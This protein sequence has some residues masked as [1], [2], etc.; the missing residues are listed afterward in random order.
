[1]AEQETPLSGGNVTPVVR[2]G[3]TVRRAAG[4]W[5]P[6]VHSLLHYLEARGFD[7]APRALGFDDQGREV[8]T[9]IEGEIGQYPVPQPLWSETVL[10]E[11]ARFIRRYHDATVGFVP[12]EGAC[13]QFVYP[14]PRR[15]EVL[16][17]NDLGP[18]NLIYVG[19][20]PRA[21][22]DFD[23]AG[24]GPR[25]WDLAYAAYCFVPL[26]HAEDAGLQRLGLTAPTIQGQRLGRFCAAYG[27]PAQEV[28]ELVE[29]R[30]EAMCAFLV[31]RAAAGDIAVQ[32][33]VEQGHLAF[34]QREL[35]RFR[36]VRSRLE[37]AC[38]YGTD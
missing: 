14:D 29:P 26:A 9:F 25:A 1:M 4:R 17:H 12:P 11:M 30:L 21:L 10:L 19:N 3:Q 35:E 27:L 31:D 2:V 18:Y 34:Y 28:L 32:R 33:M 5:T 20:R 23:M 24:P 38:I 22:I 8:L 15:H 16:C 7:G 36:Q 6:A 37:E 13:W